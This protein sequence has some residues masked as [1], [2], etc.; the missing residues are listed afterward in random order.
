VHYE[1]DCKGYCRLMIVKGN[2]HVQNRAMYLNGSLDTSVPKYQS[3]GDASLCS[4]HSAVRS[5]VVLLWVSYIF[6]RVSQSI[7]VTRRFVVC[8]QRCEVSLFSVA[9]QWRYNKVTVDLRSMSISHDVCPTN[10]KCLDLCPKKKN[11]LAVLVQQ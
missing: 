1:F 6:P 5:F 2:A 11:N 4:L 8:I 3:I 9:L 10:P 7:N